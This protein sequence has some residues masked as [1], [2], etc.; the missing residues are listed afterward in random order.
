M[1]FIILNYFYY[2]LVFKY[3]S[4]IVLSILLSILLINK[5]MKKLI[6]FIQIILITP[7]NSCTTIGLGVAFPLNP[8]TNIGVQV[9]NSGSVSGSIST[10]IGGAIISGTASNP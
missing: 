4:S 6:L 7:L 8:L 5:F 3:I 9:N 2:L 1:H 10:N